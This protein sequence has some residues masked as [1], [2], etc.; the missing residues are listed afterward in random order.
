[1][2]FGLGFGMTAAIYGVAWIFG[3]YPGKPTS[4]PRQID[5]PNQDRR[6]DRWR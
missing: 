5:Y 1:M 3:A 2:Y 6:E 4:S